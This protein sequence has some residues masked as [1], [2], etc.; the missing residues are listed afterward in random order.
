M[1]SI[2]ISTK[3]LTALAVNNLPATHYRILL[4]LMT[5]EF[6]QAKLATILNIKKQ[7]IGKV[8]KSL[9]E[10]GYIITTRTAGREKYLTANMK[11]TELKPLSEEPVPNQ[12]T[13]P[14]LEAEP[15]TE[16]VATYGNISEDDG[17]ITL[18]NGDVIY[19]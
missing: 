19:F 5:G 6:T 13:F 3:N 16:K 11:F 17:T 8:V 14:E 9:M 15:D 1:K 7:N 2:R 4:I 12:L 10:H 18:D